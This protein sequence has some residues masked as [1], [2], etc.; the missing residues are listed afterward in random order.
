VLGPTFLA[1]VVWGLSEHSGAAFIA[2]FIA[3]GTATI[4]IAAREYAPTYVETW[5]QGHQGERNTRRVLEDL[6][7]PFV[8]DVDCGRGNYDHLAV[9]PPGVFMLESKNLTGITEIRD[10]VAWLRRRHDPDGDKPLRIESTALRASAELSR[11]ITSQTSHRLW[12]QAVVV[13]WN[14]FPEGLV[15]SGRIVFVHGRRLRGYLQG[16]PPKLDERRL[17]DIDEVLAGLKRDR[18]LLKLMIDS[19][20]AARK[21]AASHSRRTL[22]DG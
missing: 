6:G 21:R 11:A 9:G 12:V 4:F 13:F 20:R 1:A 14:D 2:G 15:E 10:G 3:G 7:W 19:S 22:P 5:G 17:G 18:E 16:L 8:E